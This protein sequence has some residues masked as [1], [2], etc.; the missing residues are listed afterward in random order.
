MFF[1][2]QDAHDRIVLVSDRNGGGTSSRITEWSESQGLIVSDDDLLSMFSDGSIVKDDPDGLAAFHGSVL[3][4]CRP[5]PAK[6]S[7]ENLPQEF[8]YCLEGRARVS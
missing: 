1:H 3:S 4:V 2:R 6:V 7:V 8:L 5:C